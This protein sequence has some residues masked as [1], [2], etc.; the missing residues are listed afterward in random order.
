[1]AKVTKRS[2][3]RQTA[4]ER[5]KIG[6]AAV[7]QATGKSWPQW[8]TA[9]DKA[10]CK[11]KDHK[12]IVKATG[13]LAPE[14]GGW[15]RQMV[16][17][18]YERERGLRKMNEKVGGFALGVSRTLPV[19][20]GRLYKAWTDART[21]KRWLADPAFT[22]RKSTPNK[23]MR[24]TWVDGKTNLNVYFWVKGTAKS[25][26]SVNHDKLR[27]KRDVER[28]RTYWR[29]NLDALAELLTG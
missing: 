2:R 12:T 22:V 7:K 8:F 5:G 21:R 4:G 26:V 28:L 29:T 14:T 19:P 10:S 18:E 9:L 17:V 23:S 13:K 6:D 16:A 15:W 3:A 20:I 11:G 24:I 1:M 25:Q 27:S